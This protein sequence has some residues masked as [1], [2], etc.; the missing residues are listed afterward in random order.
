MSD[1]GDSVEDEAEEQ[2]HDITIAEA[3]SLVPRTWDEISRW[4]L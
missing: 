3:D 2:Q 1:D 4:E